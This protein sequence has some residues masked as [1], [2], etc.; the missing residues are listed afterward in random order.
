MV[1]MPV[2]RG[3]YVTSPLGPRWGTTH[4]GVDYG[5]GGS[6][7]GKPIYAIKDGTVVQAGPARGFGQW[8]R[9]DHPASVGGNE[10]V[11]G[12]VIPEVRVGQRVREGQR[13]G[14]INPDSRTNGGVVPHLHIE[15]FRYSWVPAARRVLG[16][17]IL[18]PQQ[19]LKGARWP[20]EAAPPTPAPKPQP[21]G[22]NVTTIYGVDVS[23]HQDG[24]SLKRAAS[25]GIAF[26]IIRTTD[27]TY[28]DSCYQSHLAD[29]EGA[30]LVTAAY[31]YLRNPSEGTS[32]AAQ[33]QAS[34]EVMG[35]KKRPVWIDVETPAGLHVDHIRACKR[36]FERHGVRVVGCYSYVPYWEGRIRPREPDSHE[37]G[38]FWVA[39]Y[40]ANRRGTPRAVYPGDNHRQWSYPLG[41]QK[42]VLW[43]FGS[44]GVV[45][46]R[47]VDVNAFRG[48]REELRRLFYGG[49][50]VKK[51]PSDGG[52]KVNNDDKLLRAVFEQF[53]GYKYKKDGGS[54]WAGWDALSTVESAKRKLKTTGAC[55]P[56]ELLYLANE[57]LIRRY[58]DGGK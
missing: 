39:A 22:G 23:S 33:V 55:T 58:V 31:H 24:M 19:V 47:E 28:R 35:A 26:A 8:I 38:Q 32:V 3:F 7:G 15:V 42:P 40:G 25:E 53:A 34:V 13:I 43:Q 12:H 1:T 5:N 54:T 16:S 10:S 37:F 17:T 4:W 46:G 21:K 48:S 30:G 9:V 45:A 14:R 57:D 52:K 18:D 20:G 50:P 29:A 51:K 41:N 11:Y 36:E 44:R 6:A 49:T 2:G 56:V 27:G